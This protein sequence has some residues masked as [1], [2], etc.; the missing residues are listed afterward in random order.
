M[1]GQ[2]TSFLEL[3]L[4][5]VVGIILATFILWLCKNVFKKLFINLP[6][7]ILDNH[8]IKKRLLTRRYQ[9][10]YNPEAGKR[11]EITFSK[12]GEIIKGRN[13]NENTWRVA[14]DKLELID[15]DGKVHSRFTY[16]VD[17]DMFVHTNDPDTG[18]IRGQYIEPIFGRK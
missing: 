18:S 10:V 16:K 1:D 5:S 7:I 8:R 6:K 14:L 17:M 13:D 11:K 9:L 15:S 4:V 12:D 2:A 3:V